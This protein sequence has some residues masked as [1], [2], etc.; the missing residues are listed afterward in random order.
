MEATAKTKFKNVEEYLA[1]LPAP[2]KKI[3]KELRKTIKQAAPEAEEV[4]SY[5]IP[6]LKL[7]GML[8]YYAA[9]KEHVSIYPRTAGMEKAFKKELA[10]YEG[11]KGTLKF[12]TDKPVPFD[13]ISKI[14]KLRVRENLEKASV[15]VKK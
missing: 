12:P 2:A 13:L 14:V 1:T 6:A 9:W 3:F 15:K 7:H 11:G 5:N 10:P 4:I 8:V